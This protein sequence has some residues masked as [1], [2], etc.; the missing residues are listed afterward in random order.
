MLKS[1]AK[2]AQKAVFFQNKINR[3]SSL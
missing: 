1:T 3:F 2:S